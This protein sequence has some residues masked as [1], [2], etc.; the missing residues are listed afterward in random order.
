MWRVSALSWCT[1]VGSLSDEPTKTQPIYMIRGKRRPRLGEP[2]RAESAGREHVVRRPQADML[3]DDQF[4]QQMRADGEQKRSEHMTYTWAMRPCVARSS[5]RYP[6][7]PLQ[8]RRKGP[9]K[10]TLEQ[11]YTNQ[12]IKFQVADKKQKTSYDTPRSKIPHPVVRDPT[13]S[14]CSTTRISGFL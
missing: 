2:V 3:I 14:C 8:T 10:W 9:L 11:Q 12:P 5:K 1:L 6:Q 7:N 13:A 4:A